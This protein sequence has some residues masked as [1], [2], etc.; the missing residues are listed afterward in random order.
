MAERDA[1]ERGAKDFGSKD[2]ANLQQIQSRR[3]NIENQIASQKAQLAQIEANAKIQ[4]ANIA[5][6]YGGSNRLNF[7]SMGRD[8]YNLKVRHDAD[9]ARVHLRLDPLLR[10]KPILDRICEHPSDPSVV[11]RENLPDSEYESLSPETKRLV[12]SRRALFELKD[13]VGQKKE[14]YDKVPR[15][16]DAA[17]LLVAIDRCSKLTPPIPTEGKT[18]QQLELEIFKSGQGLYMTQDAGAP[19]P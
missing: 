7:A 15:N 8:V 4:G 11:S 2:N 18:L 10:D 6:R 3:T 12:D 14:E 5:Q 13:K 17:T 19:K 16:L 9:V 1:F